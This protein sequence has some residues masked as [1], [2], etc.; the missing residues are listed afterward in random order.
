MHGWHERAECLGTPN[1]DGFHPDPD[2]WQTPAPW[3]ALADCALCPVRD[4]CLR[5]GYNGRTTTG[6]VLQGIWGGTTDTDRALLRLQGWQPGQPRPTSH[7]RFI[8]VAEAAQLLG[9]SEEVIHLW[10]RAGQLD[11]Q[12]GTAP[13]GQARRLVDLDQATARRDQVDPGRLKP[14]PGTR[15]VA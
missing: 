10:A 5:E 4:L 2:D 1:P 15:S 3:L 11:S 9:V 12:P 14:G 6:D 13:T 8:P 7:G